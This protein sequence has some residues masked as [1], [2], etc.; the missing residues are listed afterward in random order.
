VLFDYWC[1]SL[2]TSANPSVCGEHGNVYPFEFVLLFLIACACKVRGFLW[3]GCVVALLA[4]RCLQMDQ[5]YASHKL[6]LL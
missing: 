5:L 6:E 4:I 2:F 1:D 3:F